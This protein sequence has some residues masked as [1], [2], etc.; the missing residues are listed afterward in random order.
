MAEKSPESLIQSVRE[1][2]RLASD[3]EA[4]AL[5]RHAMQS[6]A[7]VL[8]RE[9]RASV[10]ATLPESVRPVMQLDVEFGDP[11]LEEQVFVGPIMSDLV[12]EGLYDQTLGGLDVLSVNAGDE[13]TRRLQAVFAALKERLDEKTRSEVERALPG[14]VA[15][16]FEEA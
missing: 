11:L 4:G 3:D 5:L 12:T 6:L 2:A 10:A 8:D 1:R 15:T 9:A 16:W 7:R 13:A 14:D